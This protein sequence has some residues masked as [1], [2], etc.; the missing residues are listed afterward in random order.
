MDN[1][2]L[3]AA[4]YFSVKF[5]G[6]PYIGEVAFKEVSG[7]SSEMEFDVVSEG[8]LND[9]KIHLPRGVK[10]SNIV[11]KRAMMPREG[12]FGLGVRDPRGRSCQTNSAAQCGDNLARR[13]GRTHVPMDVF[14][15]MAR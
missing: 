12:Y 7:L 5:Q 10:H 15:R 3:P 1:W 14:W 8:G 6:Q 13:G 9:H 2:F 4:F 11:L